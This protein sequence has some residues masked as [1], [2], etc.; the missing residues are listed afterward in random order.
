MIIASVVF[1]KIKNVKGMNRMKITLGKFSEDNKEKLYEAAEWLEKQ[2]GKIKFV[3]LESYDTVKI[4]K[5]IK[6]QRK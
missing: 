4:K 5:I 6:K 2:P 3:E 1:S